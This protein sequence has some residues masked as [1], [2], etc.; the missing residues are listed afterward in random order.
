MVC[1]RRSR[2]SASSSVER[3]APPVEAPQTNNSLRLTIADSTD[4]RIVTRSWSRGAGFEIETADLFGVGARSLFGVMCTYQRP[5]SVQVALEAI[6][7][8][9]LSP[10]LLVVVDNDDDPAVREL[11][12]GQTSVRATYVGVRPNGGPAGAFNIGLFA[13][14]EPHDDDLVVLFDDDDPPMA[15]DSIRRLVD[16]LDELAATADDISGVGLHGGL[17]DI[18]HGRVRPP[19][20]DS[21][22]VSVDHLHGYALPVYRRKALQQVGGF[23]TEVFWGFEELEL[24][25]RLTSAGHG[26]VVDMDHWNE[27]AERYPKAGDR[28]GIQFAVGPPSSGRYYSMR[29]LLRVLGR[30]RAWRAIAEVVMVRAIGKPLAGMV[31][32]PRMAMSSLAVNVLAISDAVRGRMGR[33]DRFPRVCGLAVSGAVPGRS[34]AQKSSTSPRLSRSSERAGA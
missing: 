27:V 5:D 20:G 31:I 21:G 8:Q 3:K 29:N 10:D 22:I 14:P 15:D 7:R 9:S 1:P 6:G 28:R 25:C 26:L 33:R 16:R 17:F 11:V 32:H 24:G 12:E 4:L 18:N 13:L 34:V 23:D 2:A 30:Q 19:V